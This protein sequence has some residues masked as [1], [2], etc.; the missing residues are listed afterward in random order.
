VCDLEPYGVTAA[1]H[2]G[3]TRDLVDKGHYDKA[4]F[5]LDKTQTLKAY[6]KSLGLSPFVENII[7]SAQ[8]RSACSAISPIRKQDPEIRPYHWRHG[9]RLRCGVGERRL[10]S[11]CSCGHEFSFEGAFRNGHVLSC[12]DN[13]TEEKTRRHDRMLYDHI[14]KV[15][16]DYNFMWVPRPSFHG[17]T[18]IPDMF[19]FAGDGGVIIDLTVKDSVLSRSGFILERASE[20]KDAK[21][22]GIAEE[23]NLK[24][25]PVPIDIYGELHGSGDSFIRFLAKELHNPQLRGHFIRHMHQALQ[26]GLLKGN[27]LTA[28]NAVLR[29]AC[30]AT[31]WVTR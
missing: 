1:L 20:E 19:I 12:Y 5:R 6:F 25:F 22:S 11:H 8:Q 18:K 30:R 26:V 10:P 13:H 17:N 28:D 29:L 2:Y 9:M 23:F 3:A 24:F 21:Y 4:Q 27:A 15:L 16:H 31:S 14:G 7:W